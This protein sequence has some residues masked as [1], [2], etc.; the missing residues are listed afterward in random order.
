MTATLPDHLRTRLFDML[1]GAG[2]DWTP[3]QIA[4]HIDPRTVQTPALDL[5]DAELQRLLATPSGRL[6]ISMPPQEGKSTRVARDLPIKALID[7][8]D[9]RIVVGSYAQ[10]LANRNGRAVRN[11]IAT[12]PAFGLRIAPDHGAAS[13][14]AL[15][16]HDGGVRSVGR[17]AGVTGYPADCVSGDTHIECEYGVVAAEVAYRI[18]IEWIRAYDHATG[19]PGWHRVEASRRIERRRVVEVF[20]ESGRVL[21]CTPD[22]RVHTGRGYVAAGTLV[23][24]DA[25]TRLVA[26]DGVRVRDG[27]AGAEDGRAQGDPPRAGALLLPGVHG[28]GVLDDVSDSVL[29]VRDANPEVTEEHMLGRLRSQATRGAED[30]EG[31]PPVRGRVPADLVEAHLLLP[32]LCERRALPTHDRRGELALQDGHELR[33]VVPVHAAPDPVAGWEL[34]C[35]LQTVSHCDVHAGREAGREVR[36]RDTSHQ[37]GPE[38]QYARELGNA[39]PSLPHDAPQVTADAVRVVREVRGEGVAVYD[40]QVAGARN[41]FANGLLVHNCL[42]IDDPLKDRAEADSE[43]IRDTC[44]DWWTD[45]LSARL[46]PDAPVVVILTR[47]HENDLAARLIKHDTHAGWRVLNIPAQCEDA[48]T[49]PLGRQPGEFMASARGRTR[50]QWEQRKL[51][52]GSRTWA[53]LYQ[54]RPSPAEGGI[55]RR[56]WWQRYDGQ[57]WLTDE[58]GTCWAHEG[59]LL[60]SWDMAFK[61]TDS[62]DFVVG[63]VWQQV[64]AQA[65]LL[66]QVRGRWDFAETCEQVRALSAKWP[67]AAAKL[68]EDK[69]NGPAVISALGRAIPGL[70]AVNP[71][72][73]KESRANAV[74][75][76]IEAGNVWLPTGAPWVSDLIEECAGFPNAAHDDQVDTLTQALAR[77]FITRPAR[78]G[79]RTH[80]IG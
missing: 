21:T 65:F 74:T 35:G 42:I 71:Q 54:G 40:F 2:R 48:A 58:R 53:A 49:D 52:A 66:D 56:D 62:S 78:Q 44:W 61:G 77:M 43:T 5:I 16:G 70:V 64:G 39:L 30:V 13:E 36:P 15:A 11:A 51:T 7:N 31:L 23:P 22:H 4:A 80:N 55:F 72:G 59:H 60:Q 8:P 34:L 10:G 47:W 18:G 76:L 3:G 20:T 37:R 67:Q 6:I 68:V 1:T 45:A 33:E 26:D 41:F 46:S 79:S 73:G 12:N 29:S 19:H 75:P 24:G 28:A 32:R 63:Q 17:G 57:R 14:W 69:A 9:R 50:A 27:L 38:G 25:L